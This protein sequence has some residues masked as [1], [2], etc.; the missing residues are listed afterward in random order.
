MQRFLE[1]IKKSKPTSV[2]IPWDV[3][4]NHLAAD[5]N[6]DWIPMDIKER[7]SQWHRR[8]DF[9]DFDS[10]QHKDF[11][12]VHH[13]RKK[14]K[15]IHDGNKLCKTLIALEELEK[16]KQQNINPDQQPLYDEMHEA[17]L[18]VMETQLLQL[19]MTQLHLL[20]KAQNFKRRLNG[21]SAT[22]MQHRLKELRHLIKD[23]IEHRKDRFSKHAAS[24]T[25]NNAAAF[26]KSH[27][28]RFRFT[29]HFRRT[30]KTA[31]T[32]NAINASHGFLGHIGN[33]SAALMSGLSAISAL[34]QAI[35]FISAFFTI[36]PLTINAIKMW[37]KNK[38]TTKK[39]SATFII[40][41]L[42]TGL[43]LAGIGTVTAAALAVVVIAASTYIKHIHPWIKFLLKI[44]R[45]KKELARLETVKTELENDR[46]DKLS[47]NEQRLLMLKV[48]EAWVNHRIPDDGVAF[49][50]SQIETESIA[51]LSDNPSITKLLNGQSVKDYL[52]N[53]IDNQRAD[54]EADIVLLRERERAKRIKVANG[55]L[56]VTGA[57]LICI[58]TPPTIIIG[59]SLLFI[60]AIIGICVAFNVGTKIKNLTQRLFHRKTDTAIEQS[61][62]APENS[63]QYKN[64][65]TIELEFPSKRDE[66]L[67]QSSL[68]EKVSSPAPAETSPQPAS[69]P[70]KEESDEPTH[71]HHPH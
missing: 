34:M 48:E 14:N 63:V 38:S 10:F 50:K 53:S 37:A 32:V 65:P 45:H 27:E 22:D 20:E 51:S 15:L 66:D 7:L 28:S 42:I 18:I 26:F 61:E 59:A 30:E 44:N 58:P 55:I 4:L 39:V 71:T 16:A 54:I 9:Y 29:A 23:R 62:A 67:L 70:A 47:P 41:A 13:W 24:Y 19:E 43:I 60:S 1:W 12:Q 46:L 56:A 69:E 49:L 57:I 21:V 6:A 36:I 64:R 40:A 35:P 8:F 25:L 68:T 2:E 3:Y 31:D 5:E 52:I 33:V 17:A 11:K